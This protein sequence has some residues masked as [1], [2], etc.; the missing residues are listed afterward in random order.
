MVWLDFALGCGYLN[1][2]V[3]RELFS[4]YEQIGK[5]LGAMISD[6]GKILLQG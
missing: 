3:Y 5:M 1:P 4:E 2:R 6:A